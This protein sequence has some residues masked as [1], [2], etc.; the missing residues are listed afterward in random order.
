[1]RVKIE[2]NPTE[3]EW[4]VVKYEPEK[5][6]VVVQRCALHSDALS[7]RSAVLEERAVPP[8]VPH[9]LALES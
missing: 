5:L 9:G 4:E 8:V 1:M 2:Y 7:V 6:P 3:N